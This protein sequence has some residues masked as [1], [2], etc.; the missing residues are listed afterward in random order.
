MVPILEAKA[1]SILALSPPHVVDEDSAELKADAE[2]N[3]E[4]DASSLPESDQNFPASISISS[5]DETGRDLPV[6]PIY[7]ELTE[8]QRRSVSKSAVQHIAE[9]YL[10]L[11]WSDCSQTR[12]ALLARL[13]GQVICSVLCFVSL[14]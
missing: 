2:A 10:H 11:H 6:L 9:S 14:L 5:L 12:M 1:S 13:V 8:E 3:Y 4:T 7:I